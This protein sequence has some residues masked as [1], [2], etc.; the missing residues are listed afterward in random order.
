MMTQVQCAHHKIS[1]NTH[2]GGILLCVFYEFYTTCRSGA[3]DGGTEVELLIHY[4]VR[5]PLIT[6][7]T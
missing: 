5:I 3:S 1:A 7:Y 4:K 6:V 2:M